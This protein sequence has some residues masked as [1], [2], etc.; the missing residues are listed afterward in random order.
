MLRISDK[1][2]KG[3]KI[4]IIALLAALLCLILAPAL[5]PLP[6]FVFLFLCFVAPFFPGTSFFS[7]SSAGPKR[8]Q[9]GLS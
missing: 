3:E 4:G 2:C 5:V 9:R 8:E 1:L 6:S 7:L